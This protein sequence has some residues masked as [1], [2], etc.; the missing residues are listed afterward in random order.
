MS[1]PTA[2]QAKRIAADALG[3]L[4]ESVD[5]FTT[6]SANWVF[7][8][9]ARSGKRVVVRFM[10]ERDEFDGAVLWN[11]ILRPAGVPLPELIAHR[12]NFDDESP[13]H[14]WLVLERFAGVDLE[15]AYAKLTPLQKVSVLDGVMR[16]QAIV[17][18][19]PEGTGFG[20]VCLP[21]QRP[22]ITWYRVI[23][24]GL[25]RS[26]RRIAEVG[27]VSVDVVRRVERVVP[28]F[29]D[30]LASIRPIPFLDDTTTKNVIVH[31]GKLQGIVDVDG[32]CYGDPLLVVALTRMALLKLGGDT[33]YTDA[34]LDRLS[35][36]PEQRRAVEFYTACFCVNFLSELGQQFNRDAPPPVDPAM[37]DRLM[38]ILDLLMPRVA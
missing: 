17:Q 30:Y 29:D 11:S 14:S 24:E 22:H 8:T 27:A 3:E 36:S 7:D 1:P 25:A 37:V 20:Y 6:G 38:A 32:I 21:D 4:I 12:R 16:A 18:R 10:R 2:A 33:L 34:W 19:L 35:A 26:H 9:T 15:H 5:R 31:E 13:S 28:Q 23:A